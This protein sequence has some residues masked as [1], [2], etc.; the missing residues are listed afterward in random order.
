MRGKGFGARYSRRIF[1]LFVLGALHGTFLYQ[2]DILFLYGILGTILFLFRDASVKTLVKTGIGIYILQTAILALGTAAIYFGH[3]FAPEDMATELA[4][5]QE[6]D[7]QSLAAFGS[8]TFMEAASV[9]F[10]QWLQIVGFGSLIQG[11]GAFAFF[12]FGLA[13]VK[14]DIIA[15]PSAPIWSKFRRI[16]LPI[17]LIGSAIGAYIY[18]ST[19]DMMSVEMMLGMFIMTAASPFSTAGYL[20]LI[21]KWS[22]GPMTG[23]KTFMARGGTAT[24]TAYLMQS[25]LM[26]YIFCGYGLGYYAKL[27]AAQCIAIAL[28]VAVFTIIFASVWRIYFKRGLMENLLRSWTYLGKR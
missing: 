10:T 21:A 11:F 23:F 16:F 7:I 4:S 9:R 27:G 18:T 2:G 8:G 5:M 3:Q 24:L 20:G 1:G 12:L 17:G 14:S 19:D 25:L 15:N 6:A 13:A 26:S 28:A 22:E